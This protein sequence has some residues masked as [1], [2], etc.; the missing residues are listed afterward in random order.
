M[1]SASGKNPPAN[2]GSL[3]GL[4]L[5]PW[6]GR[7]PGIGYDNTLQYSCMKNSMDRGAWWVTVH[8]ITKNQTQLNGR[9]HMHRENIANI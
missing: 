6:L 7:P 4:G 8:G 9:A 5:I 2:A 1:L 3:W